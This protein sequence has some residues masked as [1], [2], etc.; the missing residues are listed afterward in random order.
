MR[1]FYKLEIRKRIDFDQDE[2]CDIND[3]ASEEALLMNKEDVE[4]IAKNA[5]SQLQNRVIEEIRA[6]AQS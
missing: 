2:C 4:N 3:W 6:I 5:I 1:L